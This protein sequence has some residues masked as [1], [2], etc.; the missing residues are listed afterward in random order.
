MKLKALGVAM[1]AALALASTANAATQTVNGGTV[2]FNGKITNAGCAVA[3]ESQDQTVQLGEW[4]VSHFA[5]QTDTTKVPFEINLV[6][7][8]TKVA[9]TAQVS[10]DGTRD[11]TDATL[12]AVSSTGGNQ[13]QATGVGIQIF[14][15]NDAVLPPDNT[16]LSNAT[17]LIDGNNTLHFSANYK[18][19]ADVTAGQANADA[20]FRITYN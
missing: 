3:T 9:K 2:H 1:I 8:D 5:T 13:I 16:T 18:K 11:A 12:L 14:D 6:Q 10:F 4:I 17:N 19:T 7:C 20:T 15:G